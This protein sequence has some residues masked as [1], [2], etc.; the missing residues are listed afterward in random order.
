MRDTNWLKTT[1][2]DSDCWDY[3]GGNTA[4]CY[5]NWQNPV[6]GG[7]YNINPAVG[8]S[9]YVLDYDPGNVSGIFWNFRLAN[10][11]YRVYSQNVINGQL[12]IQQS[13][14]TPSSYYRK[15]TLL[16]ESSASPYNQNIGPKLKVV[17]QVWWVD[18]GCPETADWPGI[19]KCG[20]EFE[21]FLSNW[22]NY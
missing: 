2:M 13:N 4:L 12:Y 21:S 8:G 1:T 10:G 19:T 18:K 15:I 7:I 22:K 20:L 14:A 16:E 11:A 17:V 6:G 3:A 5:K 9:Y